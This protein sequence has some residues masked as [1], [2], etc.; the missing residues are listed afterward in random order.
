VGDFILLFAIEDDS[1]MKM[2]ER[3]GGQTGEL[4]G[5]EWFKVAEWATAERQTRPDG[6]EGNGCEIIS[7]VPKQGV[8]SK[9]KI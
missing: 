5:S 7:G 2:H 6:S 8:V 9:L 3:E 1:N 4:S